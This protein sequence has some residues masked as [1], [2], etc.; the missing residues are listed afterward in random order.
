MY[1]FDVDTC[2]YCQ[3]CRLSVLMCSKVATPFF[4]V[5][6]SNDRHYVTFMPLSSRKGKGKGN[7][8]FVDCWGWI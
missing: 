5:L 2:L 1:L 6:L 7:A 4:A 3:F 8:L